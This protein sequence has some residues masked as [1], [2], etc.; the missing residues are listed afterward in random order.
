MMWYLWE[1]DGIYS[2]SNFKPID[3]KAVIMMKSQNE[4]DV[5]KK[6]IELTGSDET[7]QELKNSLIEQ[8]GG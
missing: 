5:F 1:K 4:Y 7:V 8:N 2:V 6:M 3:K